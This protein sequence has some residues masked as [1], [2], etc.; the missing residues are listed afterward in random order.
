LTRTKYVLGFEIAYNLC[1][2]V[3]AHLAGDLD[4]LFTNAGS[5]ASA[6]YPAQGP[7]FTAELGNQIGGVLTIAGLNKMVIITLSMLAALYF[8]HCKGKGKGEGEEGL[9]LETSFELK[10]IHCMCTLG[11]FAC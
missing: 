10:H 11:G 5:S 7:E 2:L 4:L 1:F 9:A 3:E 6:C 8:R